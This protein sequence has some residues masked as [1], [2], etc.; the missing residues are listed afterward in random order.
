[1]ASQIQE[2]EESGVSIVLLLCGPLFSYYTAFG[3]DGHS[4]LFSAEN[5]LLIPPFPLWCTRS[6]FGRWGYLKEDQVLVVNR[7]KLL[8]KGRLGTFFDIFVNY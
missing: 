8:F 5:C 1:L 2:S 7:L 6:D 3:Y 4:N